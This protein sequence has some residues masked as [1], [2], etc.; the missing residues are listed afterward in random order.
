MLATDY[1]GVDSTTGT[2]S[3]TS[4]LPLGFYR[5]YVMGTLQD[6]NFDY[7]EFDIIVDNLPVFN[8]VL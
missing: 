1:I 3:V 5:V 2:I 4:S 8:P 7:V 6:G